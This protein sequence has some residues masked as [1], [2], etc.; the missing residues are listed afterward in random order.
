MIKVSKKH[1]LKV[2]YTI[3]SQLTIEGLK[4][5]FERSLNPYNHWV[6]L[7]KLIL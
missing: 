4:T 7:S 2:K 1:A 3:S 5:P 6:V